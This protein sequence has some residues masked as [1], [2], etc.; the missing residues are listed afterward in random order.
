MNEVERELRN[1]SGRVKT[2]D[3]RVDLLKGKVADLKALAMQ[4]KKNATD[5]QIREA[6]GQRNNGG[7]G[8]RL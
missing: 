6:K 4:F 1:S 2:G 7:V 3:L 5:L 8:L